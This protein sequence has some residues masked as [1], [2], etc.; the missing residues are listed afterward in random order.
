MT[1]TVRLIAETV[2]EHYGV[3]YRDVLS[4]RRAETTVTARMVVYLLAR[5]MTSR[6]YP[7][8]GRALGN[9]DHTTVMAGLRTIEA[10]LQTDQTLAA[11]VEQLATALRLVEATIDRFE[12]PVLADIDAEAVAHRVMATERGA[13]SVSRDEVIALA[14]AV[15]AAAERLPETSPTTTAEEPIHD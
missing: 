8:I 2:A 14:T 4:S 15:L 11:D 13:I 6:S 7:Q 12:F 9:R 1:L 5:H 10:R 3:T